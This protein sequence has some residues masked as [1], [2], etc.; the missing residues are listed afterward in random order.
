MRYANL[1][2]NDFI[3]GEGICVSLWVQGCS[4]HCL[5]C[6]NQEQWDFDKGYYKDND[7]LI[8]EI[9]SAI[10]AN[11]I[12]RNFSILGGEPLHPKNIEDTCY[13]LKKIKELFP[14]IKIY[15]WTGYTLEQLKN[16]YSSDFLKNI[17]ILI[18]GPFIISKR[19]ITLKLRGSTNQR[20]LQKGIDF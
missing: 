5:G 3:N 10:I 19:D 18:D 16:M 15:V 12:Q 1:I 6:H 17:D 9:K 2:T 20:I 4:H 7:I 11:N 14:S 8:Q 13:I